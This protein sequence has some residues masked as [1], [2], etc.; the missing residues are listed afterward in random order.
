MM[1]SSARSQ[2]F[3]AVGVNTLSTTN[4]NHSMNLG[5]KLHLSLVNHS[6]RCVLY[7]VIFH[8]FRYQI[9]LSLLYFLCLGRLL[10]QLGFMNIWGFF[11]KGSK[12]PR[13]LPN[14]CLYSDSIAVQCCQIQACGLDALF[15]KSN[16]KLS[17]FCIMLT[18][19]FIQLQIICTRLAPSWCKQGQLL[20]SHRGLPPLTQS[21]YMVHIHQFTSLT[22]SWSDCQWETPS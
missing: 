12:M 14:L 10:I 9:S 16:L 13:S 20:W 6:F 19:A 21:K 15:N 3:S 4:L 7:P 18:S 11:S 2:I 1:Q 8:C 17:K 5:K 22:Q